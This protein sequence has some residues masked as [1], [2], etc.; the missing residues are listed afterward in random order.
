MIQELMGITFDTWKAEYQPRVY[1][2]SGAECDEHGWECEC[3]FLY[4]VDL[5]DM[6]EEDANAGH[7]RRLWT[8]RNDGTIVSGVEDVRGDILITVKPYNRYMV[9]YHP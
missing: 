1:E 3:E 2:D 7:E 5:H 8:W 9:V 4:T 6:L